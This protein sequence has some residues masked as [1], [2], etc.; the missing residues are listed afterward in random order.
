MRYFW[1]TIARHTY[2]TYYTYMPMYLGSGD[3]G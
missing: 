1:S 3:D 2:I